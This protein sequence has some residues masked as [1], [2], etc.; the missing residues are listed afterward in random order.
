[1]VSFEDLRA[2]QDSFPRYGVAGNDLTIYVGWKEVYRHMSGWQNVDEQ[3]PISG[4]TLYRMYSMTKPVTVTAAMQL[5]E[6]CLFRLY[7]PLADYL[8]EFAE[9]QVF[10]KAPDGTLRTR[11]AKNPILIRHLFEMTA[12]FDYEKDSPEMRQWRAENSEAHTLANFTKHIAA[13]P[14]QFEPGT[15]W[16]YSVAH[17]VL[18][19]L[20]EV[21]SGM[22]VG[23][24]MRKNIF[25]PIGMPSATYHPTPEQRKDIC[26]TCRLDENGRFVPNDS[27]LTL[28]V[29][30]P[31]FEGGGAGLIMTVD[32]YAK[33]TAML[34]HKGKAENGERILA[35]STVDL[36]RANRLS[37]SVL[38]DFRRLAPKS[39]PGY[40]YGLGVRTHID[41]AASGSL[42]P[43][44][45][46]GWGGVLGT[47][48]AAIPETNVSIVYAMQVEPDGKRPLLRPMVT[49]MAYAA[50][51]YEGLL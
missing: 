43:V 34:T 11:P 6:H 8:P 49:S 22:T 42:T 1:M 38:D 12:G 35:E 27:R 32:D 48:M 10:E 39:R 28:Y 21:I 36:I 26:Q 24:Y 46:F 9:M 17:D 3:I 5:Y 20:V 2:F 51:E 7:D 50:L 31:K 47:Y 23:E 18:A 14:L 45:E 30:D 25:D 19:R 29:E 44:G 13:R 4:K 33:F 40:G 16:L 15:G 41:R 37:G